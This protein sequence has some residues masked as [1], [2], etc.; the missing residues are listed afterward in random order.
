VAHIIFVI[1]H[2]QDVNILRP[3]I[4]FARTLPGTEVSVLTSARFY[5]FD[6]TG[7]WASEIKVLCESLRVPIATFATEFE[8]VVFLQGQR[9]ILISSSDSTARNHIIA[10]N[11]LLSAPSGFVTAVV[12]HGFECLGFLHNAAH[13]RAYGRHIGFAADIACGWF[14][15]GVLRSI[16]PNE[17][18]KLYVSGPPLLLD[19][20]TTPST[21]A[22]SKIDSA[23]VKSAGLVCENLHSVRLG[24]LNLKGEFLTT[25]ERFSADAVDIGIDVW[26]RPHPAGRFTDVRKVAL[27]AGVQ[28]SEGPI[29]KEPFAR[30][31]FA[32][33]PPSS[34]I[35]DLIVAG[36]PVAVWQDAERQI[37]CDNYHGLPIVSGADDWWSFAERAMFHPAALL[38]AQQD[39]LRGLAIPQDVPGR[40]RELLSSFG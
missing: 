5:N 40:F 27:P 32:I 38:A 12:Q 1:D 24:D 25:F 6:A 37:D 29:Y 39:F 7:L 16:A 34:I 15:P 19:A 30:Y 9:G 21:P 22:P 2:V 17:R 31:Q 33:S 4:S 28:K 3:I 35:F 23:G 8:A 26:L 18:S 11:L 13:D 20:A 10:H 14:G 36:V